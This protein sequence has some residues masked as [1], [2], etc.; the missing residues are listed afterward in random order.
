MMAA[1]LSKW[2]GPDAILVVEDLKLKRKTKGD[3]M[4]KALRRRLN[5]WPY[6]LMRQCITHWAEVSGQIVEKIDPAYTSQTCNRCGG[7]GTR[8][9]HDFTCSCGY[10]NHADINASLNIRDTYTASRRRGVPSVTP[11]ALA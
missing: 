6:A 3:R 7:L 4:S 11:E 2:A 5:G 1:E 9:R 10:Q 8:H